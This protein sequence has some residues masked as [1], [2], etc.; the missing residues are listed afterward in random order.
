MATFRYLVRDVDAALTFYHALGFEQID[1][2][3]PA[4]A[5][6]TRGDLRVWLSGPG[7]SAARELPDGSVPAPGG[8]NRLVVEVSDLP[9]AMAPLRAI[10]AHFRSEPI[11]GPGGV[12]VVVDDPSGNPIELFELRWGATP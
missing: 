3:G 6:A 8:W 1:R 11:A 4:F 7:S 10:G 2:W 12:H 9:A 5:M